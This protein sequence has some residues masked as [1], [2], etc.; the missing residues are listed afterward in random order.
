MGERRVRT[1][2]GTERILQDAAIDAFASGLRGTLVRPSDPGYDAART[3]WNGM[4]DKRPALI[5]RCAGVADV[6]ACVNFARA[7][8]VL[9]SVRGGDHNVAGIAL[10]DGGLA[11]DLSLMKSVRV[12]RAARTARAE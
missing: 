8:D 6:I 5:A 7:N 1:T 12:D 2:T 10:C 11:I 4:I 3:L 9:V